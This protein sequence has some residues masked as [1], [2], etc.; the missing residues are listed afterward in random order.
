M[1]PMFPEGA[2]LSHHQCHCP[3]QMKTDRQSSRKSPDAR[4]ARLPA[5]VA[6]MV[7]AFA[8][9]FVFVAAGTPIPLYN[10]Y[11]AEDGITNADL[12]WVSVGYFVAAATSL[13]V[14]GRLSNHLGRR[15]VAIAALASAVLSCLILIS[16]RG[17]LPLLG[18]R[19]LQGLACGLGS[20]ALGS[21]VVDSAPARPPWLA[22]MVTSSAPM[23]G[24]PVGALISGALAEY[25]SAPTTLVYEIVATVLAICV[26]LVAISPET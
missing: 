17:A 2:W 11:R 8:F 9:V 20:T 5:H 7:A 15:P 24:I 16:M 10:I 25:G 6:F 3:V 22:A 23:V 12:G 18:A 21:Y 1:P 4:R 13:L 14:L 26:A 19:V